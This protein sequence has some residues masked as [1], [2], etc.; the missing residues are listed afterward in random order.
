[1]NKGN[2]MKKILLISILMISYGALA[3]CSARI[4]IPISMLDDKSKG[5]GEKEI[6]EFKKELSSFRK[7]K[8][9]E[10]KDLRSVEKAYNTAIVKCDCDNVKGPTPIDPSNP[11]LTYCADNRIEVDF[12]G[13][14]A[15]GLKRVDGADAIQK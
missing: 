7:V 13:T 12:N 6:C 9:P 8:T 11:P 14:T 5:P 15:I 2:K 10:E 3:N 4:E 1:M